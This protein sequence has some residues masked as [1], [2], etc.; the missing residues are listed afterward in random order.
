[1]TDMS[2]R[3]TRLCFVRHGETP[4]NAERRIQGHEDVGLNDEGY[5]QARAAARGLEGEYF[6]ALYSS[7]L[8]R[9]RE[10]AEALSPPLGLPIRLEPGL[11]ERHYGVFQ[12]LTVEEMEHRYPEAGRRYH[13][14]DPEFDFGHGE[15]LHTFAARI[16]ATVARLAARHAGE[17]VVIVTHGGVLDILYRRATG[18]DLVG[19]RDFPIPNAGLNWIEIG[20]DGSWRLD[21]WADRRHLDATL[22]E[23]LR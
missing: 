20:A 15:S 12:G 5:A 22:E 8:R 4:W 2:C 19:P 16:E 1:M 13:A 9:A 14:R 7:D 6:S 21:V 3:P 17:C 10:T 23:F 11:R 18:R